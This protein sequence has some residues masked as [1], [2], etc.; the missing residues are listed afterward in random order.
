[1]NFFNNRGQFLGRLGANRVPHF[2]QGNQSR[3]INIHAYYLATAGKRTVELFIKLVTLPGLDERNAVPFGCRNGSKSSL[4]NYWGYAIAGATDNSCVHT[5]FYHSFGICFFSY[6]V[7]EL[8]HAGSGR[9]HYRH[10][11]VQ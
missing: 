10:V 2:A 4:S 3:G 9:G 8:G 6:G 5:A 1:M 11:Q 7:I